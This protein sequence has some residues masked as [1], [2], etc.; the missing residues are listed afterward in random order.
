MAFQNDR[1]SNRLKGAT[2]PLTPE[3]LTAA[4]VQALE[5]REEW[6]A[7]IAAAE[8][9]ADEG[10]ELSP[11]PPPK[12]AD[13]DAKRLARFANAVTRAEFGRFYW[14]GRLPAALNPPPRMNSKGRA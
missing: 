11:V 14:D 13:D 10:P 12:P 4:Y 3:Q 8:V 6:R 2:R 1:R 7:E 5:W 9:Q